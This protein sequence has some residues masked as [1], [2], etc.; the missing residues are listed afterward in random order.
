MP[1]KSQTASP[2]L[3]NQL[4]QALVEWRQSGTL[5]NSLQDLLLFKQ[6][7]T[8]VATAQQANHQ[9]LWQALDAL[10]GQDAQAATLLRRHFY[11]NELAEQ[12]AHALNWS[13]STYY[14]KQNEALDRLT[15]IVQ[16]LEAQ[17]RTAHQ[18]AQL[19]RLEPPTYTHLIG[20]AEHLDHLAQVLAKPG[21]P[22]LVAIVGL[23]GLG[24]TTLADALA[25][26]LLTQGMSEAVAWV[27]ARQQTFNLGG[28]IQPLPKPVL[29][30]DALA[31][32]LFAQVL[33]GVTKPPT[34]SSADTLNALTQRLQTQP[35]LVFIDNLETV[36]DLES[37]LP[38]LRRLANPTRFVLT[39]RHSLY[40]EADI[41][42]FPL[43]ELSLPQALALIRHE[44]Q[45]RNLPQ[46]SQAQ[47]HELQP[48]HGAV[49]GNPLAIRLVVGQLHVHA[50]KTV[51]DDLT[52][53]QSNQADSFY[54]FVYRRAWE[55][56][57]ELERNTLLAM[58]MVTE[59]GGTLD[60]L[61]AVSGLTPGE[62]KQA[63]DQLVALNLVDSRGDLHE[64]RY[65]IHNLTRTFL[66]KQVAKWQAT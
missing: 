43:P 59:E 44:A 21:P 16:T 35:H 23:G 7:R 18:A 53:A 12:L 47:D 38:F 55:N 51:L 54:T 26:H 22:W 63:L 24:K 45:V 39:T 36:L 19:Q 28:S 11:D 34:F 2:V 20:V 40:A 29:T 64:R 46:V 27:T 1:R 41:Y 62:L 58:P 10:Q 30:A 31:E 15:S 4:H 14:R 66:H 6:A 25:R 32:A 3:R 9:L 49:G 48:I 33:D 13:E 65:S 52:A 42:H 17:A 8:A 56:L 57:R 60:Y 5:G 37:L 50:L 61:A